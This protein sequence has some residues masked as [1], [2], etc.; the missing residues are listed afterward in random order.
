MASAMR[1]NGLQIGDRVA[2]MQSAIFLENSHGSDSDPHHHLAVVT[3]SIEAVTL[4]LA[5]ASIGGIYSST[6]T[7][8]GTQV[9]FP[10][11]IL[12]SCTSD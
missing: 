12:V 4:A 5:T 6:A 11:R 7:D 9:R 1:A 2:G 10:D 8:M 3:N